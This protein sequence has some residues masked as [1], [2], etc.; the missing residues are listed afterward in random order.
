MKV[1]AK[2]DKF[3]GMFLATLMGLMLVAV[4]WQVF[5]RY[6]MGSASTFTEELAR[7]LLIWIG[8]LGAAYISGR[9]MHLAIDLLPTRLTGRKKQWLLAFINVII[10]VFAVTAFIIGGGQLVYVSYILGQTSPALD[11]PLAYIY[12]ILPLS[13]L[14]VV[15]YKVLDLMELNREPGHDTGTDSDP[16]TGAGPTAAVPE[17]Q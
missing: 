1:K 6:V 2:I 10:I 17:N 12:M 5:T 7:Y 16:G 15:Y 4:L 13:G 11:I 8:L 3:I 9:N 14:L